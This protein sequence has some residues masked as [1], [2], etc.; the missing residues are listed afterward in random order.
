MTKR[1]DPEKHSWMTAE[2]TCAV[3]AALTKDGGEARFVGGAVRNALIGAKVDEVD[4]AT[5]LT[6]DEVTRRLEAAG[7]GAVPTG[8]EHGTVTAIA[9]GRPFE[10][11]TLRRDVSTDGRRAVVA[12]TKDWNE[13]AQRRDFTMNA[14]YASADGALFDSVGGVADLEKGRVRFIGDAAARIREDYLRILRL[15]RFHAWYGK[16]PLDESAMAAAAAGKAGL[17]QLSGERIQKEMLKLLAAPDPMPVL[18]EMATR[19]ILMEILPHGLRLDRLSRMVEIDNANNL[20]ADPILRLAAL[21]PDTLFS[22][23][24]CADRF[25]L[26]NADRERILTAAQTIGFLTNARDARRH[27]YKLGP[28]GFRD[29]LRFRWASEVGAPDWPALLR[30]AD[31]WI[32]QEFPIN[33]NDVMA[34]GI[35]EGPRIGNTLLILEDWWIEQDFRPDR[36]A[37]LARLKDLSKN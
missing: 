31:T 20:A 23:L 32:A 22:I 5:P 29:F 18:L 8:I 34:A 17:A 4:I 27:I 26:S 35:P 15:F 36:L 7:L 6:P 30:M 25:R 28:N 11:T 24:E 1:L 2:P 13:D 33:G 19:G 16:G 12:F 3:M 10:V 37:L 9:F 21:L 14:L